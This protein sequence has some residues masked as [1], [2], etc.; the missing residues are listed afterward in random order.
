MK[1]KKNLFRGDGYIQLFRYCL[2][3]QSKFEQTNV[4]G[5]YLS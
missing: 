2:E 4:D 3:G 1:K 5:V